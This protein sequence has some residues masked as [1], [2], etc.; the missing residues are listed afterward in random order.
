MA[1]ASFGRKSETNAYLNARYKFGD[2]VVQKTRAALQ[3]V[4]VRSVQQMAA[5]MNSF[6]DRYVVDVINKLK[7]N[8]VTK[9]RS[10]DAAALPSPRRP[11]IPTVMNCNTVRAVTQW[12]IHETGVQNFQTGLKNR[13]QVYM[14]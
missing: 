11:G 6:I 10:K 7:V 12:R 4:A 9:G 1:L 14:R 8:V 13:V 2:K 5:T 3:L